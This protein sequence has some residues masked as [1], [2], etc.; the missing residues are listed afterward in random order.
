MNPR[1]C[2]RFTMLLPIS[3]LSPRFTVAC[4]HRDDRQSSCATCSVPVLSKNAAIT[5]AG[6]HR[7]LD[8]WPAGSTV[9]EEAEY[10]GDALLGQSF[11]QRQSL[12][13]ELCRQRA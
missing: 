4:C 6:R 11:P 5:S 12:S 9:L 8:Q 1:V 10:V 13:H 7:R 3:L 2:V